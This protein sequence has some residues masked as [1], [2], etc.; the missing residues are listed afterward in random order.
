[1]QNESLS[2][3]ACLWILYSRL[4]IFPWHAEQDARLLYLLRKFMMHFTGNASQEHVLHYSQM[5][6]AAL[7]QAQVRIPHTHLLLLL[8]GA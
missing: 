8:P 7:V 4:F 5:I 6:L 1:M 3:K 2:L